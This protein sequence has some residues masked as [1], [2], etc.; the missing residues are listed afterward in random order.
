MTRSNLKFFAVALPSLHML[1]AAS[2]Q[3]ADTRELQFSD[4]ER[5]YLSEC[6]NTLLGASV[7]EDGLISQQDFATAF[8]DFCSKFSAG[9]D[10][11]QGRFRTLPSTVQYLFFEA[12]CETMPLPE[13]CAH[14]LNSL[15]SMPFGYIVS[16]ETVTQV[17]MHVEKLCIEMMDHVFID[18]PP[19]KAPVGSSPD[20]EPP[21]AVDMT[22]DVNNADQNVAT[23]TS[24]PTRKPTSKP[25]AAPTESKA[26]DLDNTASGADTTNPTV[27]SVP[28]T[29]DS[30]SH[31]PT[32]AIAAMAFGCLLL[33]LFAVHRRRKM[34]MNDKN[35]KNISC[36]NTSSDSDPEAPSAYPGSLVLKR[37]D[38]FSAFDD[39]K[40][41]KVSLAMPSDA[42]TESRG[43]FGQ[44]FSFPSN[45][46]SMRDIEQ[47]VDNGNW[48]E[49]YQLASRLAEQEDVSTLSSYGRQSASGRLS[50]ERMERRS[51]LKEE[52]HERV[53]TLDELIDSRDWTGVAVTA[54]LYAGESGYK[55][56]DQFPKSS[57][58]SRV[59]SQ[60]VS[61]AARAASSQDDIAAPVYQGSLLALGAPTID[62]GSDNID[63]VEAP[64]ERRASRSTGASYSDAA[65]L[66]LKYSMD[67]AVEAG[68][69]DQVVRISSEIEKNGTF[70]SRNASSSVVVSVPSNMSRTHSQN[71]GSIAFQTLVGEMNQAMSRGDWALVGFYADKIRELKSGNGEE[72]TSLSSRSLA[73]VP[74]S[75]RPSA[76]HSAQTEDAIM[77][78]KQTLDKLVQAQKWKGVS[79]MAG[80]YAMEEKDS[81]QSDLELS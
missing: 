25:T 18:K 19:T 33:V 5:Q 60:R 78:R 30:F 35:L 48:D 41:P 26:Q 74:F 79:I 29:D 57:F 52:D 1:G 43:D 45:R 36:D 63:D 51:R 46:I 67:Q 21:F 28:E 50:S 24:K 44:G 3:R 72:S 49:V 37:N 2:G 23:E 12:V 42:S 70:Q 22:K 66:Q 14:R 39:S 80:L 76:M 7:V 16:D 4:I 6:E 71:D 81:L 31:G 17:Q 53:K 68:D 38:S 65:L 9:A 27:K 56:Q 10:C 11:P 62:T 55:K 8:T 64:T 75:A 54:A 15:N 77:T 32:V 61:N 73:L 34:N 13:Q 58:F 20:T 59:T 40:V 47:A 69:W